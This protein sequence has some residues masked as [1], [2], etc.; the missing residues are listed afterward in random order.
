MTTAVE[1]LR[2]LMAP[3]RPWLSNPATEEICVNGPGSAFVW[4]GGKF[5]PIDLHLDTRDLMDIAI[6]AGAIRRQDV[7][8]VQ[9]LLAA[10]LPDGERMQ[11]VLPPCVAADT[12]S[13]TIRKASSF[14]PTLD[15][16]GKGGLFDRTEGHRRAMTAEDRRLVDLHQT[17][18]WMEFLRAAVL[19]KK[20]II[21]AG[22]TGSGKTTVA[23]ALIDCM[24]LSER[25]ITIED[26]AEWGDIPHRNR[27]ALFYSKGGQ[28]AARVTAQDLVEAALRMRIGRLL[29]QEIRDG[30][31]ASAFLQAVSSGHP[32]GI[33]TIHA[34]SADA[35]FTRLCLEL[36]RGSSTATTDEL[37]AI[38]RENIHVIV[39]CRQRPEDAKRVI[40]EVWFGAA[41][42]ADA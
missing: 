35:A 30:G 38:L 7:G 6:L 26:T 27:V 42:M 39:H 10:E 4:Q 40:S 36:R 37:M 9:P 11:V 14:A 17:G 23:K 22:D 2:Y 19:A 15:V 20:T 25:L 13:L 31:A 21:L 5:A 1:Q 33:T 34:A 18:Q 12:V 3:M 8:P 24:P 32:G 16:L 41:E 29:V 28:G